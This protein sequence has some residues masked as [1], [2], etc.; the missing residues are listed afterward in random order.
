MNLCFQKE[1]ILAEIRAYICWNNACVKRVARDLYMLGLSYAVV[2]AHM[3]FFVFAV[4]S[5]HMFFFVFAVVSAHMFFLVFA[6][7]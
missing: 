3:S 7:I 1:F 2:S 5:A 6:V 4:V